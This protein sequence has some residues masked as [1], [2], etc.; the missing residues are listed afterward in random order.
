[1]MLCN[2]VEDQ[3]NEKEYLNMLNRHIVDGIITGCHTLETEEYRQIKKPIVALDR[4][5]GEYIP[6]VMANHKKGGELAAHCL[7]KSGCRCVA[8]FV[9]STELA[10]PYQERHRSFERVMR[11][12][13]VEV[14][15]FKLEWN[16][17]DSSYFEKV[18]QSMFELHP[19]VDGV[20]GAD[21]L[22]AGYLKEAL[23]RGKRVPQDIRIVAYD[24]TYIT[25]IVTPSLTAVVQPISEIARQSVQLIIDMIGGV[26]YRN[27]KVT[28]DVEVRS[29]GTT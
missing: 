13:G 1:M 29:G 26:E 17:F 5:L 19:E 23:V 21:M 24:G 2:T 11:Q 18:T 9:E 7:L 28:V 6:I 27:K 3:N 15:S 12:N 8:Q 14:Y 25:S 22:A 10:S 4:D 16:K 20:F